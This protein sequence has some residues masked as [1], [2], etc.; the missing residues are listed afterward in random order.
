[1]SNTTNVFDFVARTLAQHL[2]QPAPLTGPSDGTYGTVTDDL[3]TDAPGFEAPATAIPV[4]G[5]QL[6]SNMVDDFV[7]AAYPLL[8][9]VAT[10]GGGGGSRLVTTPAPV[11]GGPLTALTYTLA[12]DELLTFFDGG[13]FPVGDTLTITLPPIGSLTPGQLMGIQLPAG[14]PNYDITFVPDAADLIIDPVTGTPAG[15]PG[16]PLTYT[17]GTL[18]PEAVI[19]WEGVL[20][21]ALSWEPRY[22]QGTL[23]GGS[24]GDRW[25][26]VLAAGPNSNGQPAIHCAEDQ[27]LF[28]DVAA[29]LGDPTQ[30]PSAFGPFF[31]HQF[32]GKSSRFNLIDAA[33][34]VWVSMGAPAYTF[35]PPMNGAGNLVHVRWVGGYRASNF[36]NPSPYDMGILEEVWG[37]EFGTWYKLATLIDTTGAGFYP[38]QFRF[39]GSGSSLLIELQ[40]G[41]VGQPRQARGVVEFTTIDGVPAS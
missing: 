40:G 20:A 7:K 27:H 25:D 2:A 13:F 22:D 35:P 17:F 8:R 34:G 30:P 12:A 11:F 41:G 4:A 24:G 6:W 29:P 5:G 23:S 15:P 33:G 31:D 19:V 32:N 37:Y 14:N 18:P 39:R 16:T 10:G 9:Q 21:P 36:A 3:K 38:Q 28:S 1:M 26:L